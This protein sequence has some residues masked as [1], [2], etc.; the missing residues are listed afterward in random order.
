[1]KRQTYFIGLLSL[2]LVMPSFATKVESKPEAKATH[3]LQK[4]KENQPLFKDGED[5]FTYKNPVSVDVPEDKILIQYFYQYGC[6]GCLLALDTLNLYVDNH[7][8][9]LILETSPSFAKN[10]NF[11]S[12]MNASFKEYGK[13]ELSPLYLFDSIHRKKEKSLLDNNDEIRAW[14]QRNGIDD[15]QFLKIFHSDLVKRHID[16]DVDRFK[17]YYAPSYV[18]MAVLNGKYILL[19]ST[20]YND[21]YTFGV[22]DFLIEKLQQEQEEKNGK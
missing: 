20:L 12:A 9:K 19:R 15:R 2:M 4:S 22:L 1:M 11:T 16:A 17:Q 10:D 5:Y 3:S 7:A 8:D 13:P 14:L 21:D 18:P 6:K